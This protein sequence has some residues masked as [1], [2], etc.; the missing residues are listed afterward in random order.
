MAQRQPSALRVSKGLSKKLTE[1]F[2]MENMKDMET[3]EAG[4]AIS[5][6][7]L[8]VAVPP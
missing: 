3:Q 2:T 1:R 7:H 5:P 6:L 4:R 8:R